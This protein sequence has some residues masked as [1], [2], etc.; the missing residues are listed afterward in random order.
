MAKMKRSLVISES[1]V[2]ALAFDTRSTEQRIYHALMDKVDELDPIS[3]N[4]PY[5]IR[6]QFRL[7]GSSLSILIKFDLH[8][9]TIIPV[10]NKVYMADDHT[11]FAKEI[12]EAYGDVDTVVEHLQRKLLTI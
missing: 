3:L 4:K 2:K 11:T 7:N 6:R 8:E 1:L 12:N 10:R 9:I 5:Q